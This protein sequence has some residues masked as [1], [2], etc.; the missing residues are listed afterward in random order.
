MEPVYCISSNIT[1]APGLSTDAA[2]QSIRSGRGGVCL[3]EDERLHSRALQASRL[4]ES[5]WAVINEAV[6]AT[7]YS[8]LEQMAIYSVKE[9]ISRLREPVELASTLLIFSSTKGNIEWLGSEPDECNRLTTSAAIIASYFGMAVKP[10]V[11][12]HACVSG[13]S[14]SLHAWRAIG[15]GRYKSAIVVGVDRLTQFVVSGFASFQALSD[16]PCRPFDA[17]RKG[18][19]LG[20]AAATLVFSSNRGAGALARLCAGATSNDANHI[21]GPSRTGAELAQAIERTLEACSLTPADIGLISAH[22]TATMY[23]DEMESRAFAL[24]GLLPAQVHSLKGYFGHT[25]GAAGVLE[26]ALL[27]ECIRR[28]QTIVSAGYDAPGVSQPVNVT[29]TAAA[30]DIRYALKTASGFGGC[31]ATV[32]WGAVQ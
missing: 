1:A 10:V 13:V 30:L 22:G 18:I 3:I 15:A 6:P 4:A 23:N 21:S 16:E 24:A 19:N 29:T 32:V 28:Q 9:A 7:A 14:A 8:P 20:E 31:N 5:Q 2:W 27:I 12:S 25:L 17:A 11:I 26:S